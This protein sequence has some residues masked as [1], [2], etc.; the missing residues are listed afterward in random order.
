MLA[1]NGNY[2]AGSRAALIDAG[3]Q[4]S[5]PPFAVAA[6]DGDPSEF[7]RI[8]SADYQKAS[9]AEPLYL[10]GWQLV[11]ELNRALAG[12]PASGYVAPP[13]LITRRDVPT[14]PVYEPNAPYRDNFRRIWGV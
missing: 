1:I 11:D 2:F 14:G 5:E 10:Q 4:G 9:I 7:E 6:G 3:R 8:R 12:R 13:R